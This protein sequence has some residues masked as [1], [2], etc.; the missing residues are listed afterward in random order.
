M[1]VATTP[2]EIDDRDR[3]ALTQYLTV[4][5][6]LD[7]ARGRE[8]VYAVVSQS[9]SQYTV[10][11]GAGTCTCPDHEYRGVRCKHLRRVD[12]ATGARPIPAR[13]DRESIDEDLGRHIDATPRLAAAD[14]GEVL[15]PATDD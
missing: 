10:D 8:G 13:I 11:A 4:L 12:F 15:E 2:E 5:E 14:G 6:D 9:G 3:R 7:E 1:A